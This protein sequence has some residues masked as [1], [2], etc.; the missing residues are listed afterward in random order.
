MTLSQNEI[1]RYSRHLNLPGFGFEAQEK[2]KKASVLV[3]GTGGLG[4]P[5][6]QYL[7][8]AGVGKI[9]VVDYD[10]IDESNLQRQVL[11]D[12]K[13][14]GKYKTRVAI[15]R[16]QSQNPYVTFEEYNEKL[17]SANALSIIQDFDIVADGTDNFPTRYL[18]NDACV[19]LGKTNVYA[20]IYQFEGQVSVFNLLKN[21]AHGPNYRDLFPTPPP[22]DLVPNCAEGGVLGV[23]PGIIGSL[24]ASEVIKVITGLGEPLS[25][26][27]LIMDLLNHT[28]RTLNVTK[29]AANPLSGEHPEITKL[30]DYEAFCG[31]NQIDDT[32]R[33]IEPETLNQML[34]KK[35]KVL[36]LDVREPY[37][38]KVSNIGGLLIPLKSIGSQFGDIPR[39]R[40]VIVY[41]KTGKRSR[42]AIK[43]LQSE[44]GFD[45][46]YNLDGG[47]I[48]WKERVDP[49]IKLA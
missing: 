3:V 17:T 48:A 27:L 43:K 25:G 7:S 30:I 8:A 33:S 5:L 24:Q 38:N 10:I 45:N 40:K 35:S 15:E 21:G 32:I 22:P 20:S 26:K 23:L 29:D 19:L 42:Q 2:L 49:E 18:C 39:D 13:D 46:L 41:C 9:G 34:K 4:A 6:L 14:I 16:L 36:L 1:I 37:E 28:S 47:L 12:Q 31:V 11:F 44:F